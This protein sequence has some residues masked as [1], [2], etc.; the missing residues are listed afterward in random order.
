MSSPFHLAS[1]AFANDNWLWVS[2]AFL[3]AA[4][5][6]LYLGYRNSPLRGTSR[7]LA[8]F[9]KGLG[10]TLLALSLM[11]PVQIDE[12]PKKGGN[13]LVILADNSRGLSV[14][15]PADGQPLGAAL[16][17]S[18][19]GDSQGTSPSWM[20]DLSETFRLDRYT[21]DQRLKRSRDF[22]DL[23]FS[24]NASALF[25]SL[26]SIQNRYGRRPLAAT[27]LFSDGNATDAASMEAVLERLSTAKEEGK[28]VAPVFP[29]VVG[30]DFE[31]GFDLALNSVE[32]SHS[33]F[34]DAPMTLAVQALLRGD[35]KGGAEV[36]VMDANGKEVVTEVAV[37]PKQGEVRKFQARIK[38]P[39]VPEGVSFY[40][41]GI[42]E[43]GRADPAKELTMEN[44]ERVV[45]VDR[46]R[47]PYRVLY[48]SGRPNWEFKFI[49]RAMAGDSEIDLVGLIRIA[50]REPKFEWRGR[51]GESSNP[52][53]RGF[54]K[55]IPEETQQYD[56]PVLVRLN[57]KDA[58][59]LRDGFPKTAEV[60]FSSYR[61]IVLDDV[62]AEYFTQEQQNLLDR[63][64]AQRG[65]TVIMLG[66]QES[67]QQG[68]WD[69]T[70]VGRM[71]PVYLDQAGRGGPSL[72]ATYNLSREG[73]LQ[74]WMR[75]RA[76]Q[77][78]EETRLAYMPAHY[79]I[80]Q[81]MAI[82][83]GA[84]VLAT[85]T[86]NQQREIPALVTQRYGEG[87]TA[88]LTVGDMWRWGMKD[89][90]LREDLEKSWRQLFRWAVAEVPGRVQLE[91][92]SLSDGT[93]P[94]TEI[95]VRVKDREFRP[96]DDA[97][98]KFSV[99]RSG[100]LK[101][102][103]RLSGEPSLED[104]G[105]FTAKHFSDE[106]GGYLLKA[107]ARNGAGEVIDE[108]ETGWAQNPAAEEFRN[109]GADRAILEKIAAATGGKIFRLSELDDL[110]DVL[111]D[112]NVPVMD[113]RQRPLWHAFWVFAL[114]LLCFLGEWGLRR[115]KGV[116]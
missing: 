32:V 104:A 64:V 72:E 109:I 68:K 49:R 9:L 81:I 84:S 1:I 57:T 70:S 116:L 87:K 21:F 85:V 91:T 61:A 63:F 106:A 77:A 54:K 92:R 76:N 27:V 14:R 12:L 4:F 105:V 40:R 45:G 53:F 46:G 102:E 83:P 114:A 42:R 71:L 38:I 100:D 98:V 108:V 26:Y 48:V 6:L 99:T 112:L 52:I 82:K 31:G 95:T 89:S 115:W 101:K 15:N 35:L 10:L 39:G 56:Q 103:T 96:Q 17:T 58:D 73:W 69:K 18:L 37:F 30:D 36:F 20:E 86:D 78:D 94:V 47:G 60:L 111:V 62:E 74:P 107:T 22:L 8:V 44:N 90:L 93:L 16:Q 11:E 59:E 67:F 79:S 110:V 13:D 88:A 97:S 55:D 34:E 28:T 23:D 25:T 2:A 66:G 50:K 24:G 51:T 33:S 80:N 19:R 75:L 3:F 65:G 5:V 43:K 7:W 113:I 29:V 41:I